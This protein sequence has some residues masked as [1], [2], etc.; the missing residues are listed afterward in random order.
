[1]DMC[2]LDVPRNYF[3]VIW[4]EGSIYFYGFKNALK[5]W[6]SFFRNEIRFVFSEPNWFE[7]N[8]PDEVLRVWNEYPQITSISNTIERIKNQGYEVIGY[9]KLPKES[10]EIYYYKP[11]QVV[12]NNYI[13]ENPISE[14]A[15]IVTDEIQT[16]IND[17]K[18]YFRYYG[19]TFYICLLYWQCFLGSAL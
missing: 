10:W 13:K 4:A 12:L 6:K 9:F 15:K 5:N 3:D 11:L 7:K 18:K 2:K 1:M 8:I 14:A 19:Y 17:Y 16:E